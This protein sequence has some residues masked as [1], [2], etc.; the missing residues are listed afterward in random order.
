MLAI[1]A[2]LADRVT[3]LSRFSIPA[4]IVG[5]SAVRGCAP[6]CCSRSLASASRGDLDTVDA[7]AAVLRLDRAHRRPV[8]AAPRRAAAAAVPGRAVPVPDRAG[9]AR[10]RCWRKLL[11]LHPVLGLVGRHRSPWS[12]ATAPGSAYAERFAA[13]YDLLGVM[14]LTMTS[15]TIG[16]VI[17]GVIGGPVARRPDPAAD[18]A[19]PDR[20]GSERRRGRRAGE[21]AGHDPHADDCPVGGAGAVIAGQALGGAARRRGRHRAELPVVPA[22][23]ARAPQR[24]AARRP[25]PARRGRRS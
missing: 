23:R 3:L 15:A 14:G 12:A 16:L 20:A 5:G 1:G 6:C 19:S 7:A 21:D 24:L 10:H 2:F 11:G 17:G 13:D 9:R 8:A 22:G 4:P 18:G 25:A